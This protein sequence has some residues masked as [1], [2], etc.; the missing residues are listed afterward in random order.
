MIERYT[1]S[2]LKEI[3]TDKYKFEKMLDIE[4]AICEA[5]NK[6]GLIPDKDLKIIQDKALVDLRDIRRREKTT[7]HETVAFIESVAHKVG[8]SGKYLH[9]GVTSSDILDT[10]QSMQIKESLEIILKETKKF[11]R[12]LLR[13]AKKYKD[14]LMVGRT[15]GM[16]AEPVTLGLKF[17]IW[18]YE[19]ERNIQRLKQALDAISYGKISGSVGT[20]SQLDP[21]I[22]RYVCKKLKLKPAK[23]STQILQRDRYADVLYST[24]SLGN[25]LEKIALEI[26]HLHRTE[27]NEVKEAFRKGQKGSSS[28]PHKKNPILCER[29]CGQARVLRGNLSIGMENNSLWHE[30]DMS[31]SSAE[32]VIMPDS[33]CLV[34]FMLSDM[35]SVI[36]NLQTNKEKIK[37]NLEMEK[38]KIF[39]QTL[40][41]KLVQKGMKKDKAYK[42]VQELSFDKDE[43]FRE[44]VLKHKLIQKY[45]T[46]KDLDEMLDLSY[47]T[48][49]VKKIFKRFE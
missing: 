16:H 28:M 43:D 22:E 13:K 34:H 44:E 25:T 30:R 11:N 42:L 33:L 48:R 14:L 7:R 18:H 20:Y 21:Y 8:E 38:G 12:L 5:W 23:V 4:L 29:I 32:R 49:N 2:P 45:L 31:H 41:L 35:Y 19:T 47:Y 10:G 37:E 46:K 1:L 3:W 39:S 17:L 27:V 9:Y 15:H 40:M 6:K 24:T 26:R 36:D